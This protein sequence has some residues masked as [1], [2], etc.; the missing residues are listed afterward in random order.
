MADIDV[1]GLGAVTVD[2]LVFISAFPHP[3]DKMLVQKRVRQCGG[4]SGTALVAAARLGAR[5]A[6]AG[7]LGSD[8]LSNFVMQSL[9]AENVNLDY[10]LRTTDARPILS[11]ILVDISCNTRTILF[12][13]GQQAGAAPDHP[14]AD[15]IRSIRVLF[16]D[17]WG[18][19]GM[20]RAAR[21]AREAGIPVVADFER[22]DGSD[23]TELF[24][25]VNHLVVSER[26]ALEYT[27]RTSSAEALDALSEPGRDVVVITRGDKGCIYRI[28][29]S[30]AACEM[31][32]FRVDVVDTTGCGDVFHGAYCATLARG[33]PLDTRIRIASAAASLKSTRSGGQAGIPNWA[34]VTEFLQKQAID[35]ARHTG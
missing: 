3:D 16:V 35:D 24:T 13:H 30:S 34:Q 25:L 18:S 23:F 21:L 11:T 7:R 28:A 26:F 22:A 9:A 5:A 33:L 2:D 8:D 12:D 4:L 27:L 17:Q 10:T 29:G 14:S 1:L 31:P 32:A 15:I 6:Y 20:L 19:A